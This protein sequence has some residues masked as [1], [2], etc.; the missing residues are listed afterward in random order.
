MA[1]NWS[2]L[3]DYLLWAD[4]LGAPVSVNVV[5][6]VGLALHDLPVEQLEEVALGWERSGARPTLNSEVW[7]E[8]VQQMAAVLDERRRDVPPPPRH[9]QPAPPGVLALSNHAGEVIGDVELQRRRLSAWSG[10]GPVAEITVDPVGVVTGVGSP[11]PRL[12][13]DAALIGW[14][15]TSVLGA[16]ERADGR[17]AWLAGDEQVGDELVRT[18]VLAVE[19]PERGNPGSVVRT[20]S[21]PTAAGWT[22]LVAEDR[23]YEGTPVTFRSR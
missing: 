14:P 16:I 5:S 12:G 1:G 10:E 22:V 23:L 18:L 9:A 15:V 8:Q 20:V 3:P 4:S 17:T 11:H 6:E 19:R 7:T 21:V 13:L 2:E